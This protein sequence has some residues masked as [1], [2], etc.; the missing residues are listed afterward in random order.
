MPANVNFRQWEHLFL[1][2]K[3]KGVYCALL[4][5]SV[6][7]FLILYNRENF[8]FFVVIQVGS[9]ASFGVLVDLV[10]HLFSDRYL[11]DMTLD[12]WIQRFKSGRT[13]DAYGIIVQFIASAVDFIKFHY[14][15]ILW[16]LLLLELY[17][18]IKTRFYH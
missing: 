10:S 13:H 14:A 3:T 1:E 11:T 8:F 6:F 2:G 18:I 15:F 7:V 5:F 9:F 17:Y 4:S 16:I 12:Q